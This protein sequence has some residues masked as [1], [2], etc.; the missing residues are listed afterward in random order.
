MYL[1]GMCVFCCKDA[2]P[3]APDPDLDQ[4]RNR[5]V[6]AAAL[7]QAKALADQVIEDT[8]LP[9]GQAQINISSS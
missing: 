1:A 4:Q 3:G 8:L 7:T 5:V 2:A 9:I 6:A